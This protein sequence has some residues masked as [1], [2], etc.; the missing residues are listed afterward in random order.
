[1]GFRV[2]VLVMFVFIMLFNIDFFL[3]CFS[4]LCFYDSFI[5][6]KTFKPIVSGCIVSVVESTL[7]KC[8]GICSVNQRFFTRNTINSGLVYFCH[9]YFFFFVM[10]CGWCFMIYVLM[11]LKV[12]DKAY[13]LFNMTTHSRHSHCK[14]LSWENAFSLHWT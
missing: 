8:S 10:Y 5:P 2:C 6:W 4:C 3:F 7:N 11:Y 14:S 12:H 1:M 13:F 9:V